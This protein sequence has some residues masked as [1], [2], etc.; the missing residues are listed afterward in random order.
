MI[1][2]TENS[3]AFCSADIGCILR[4]ADL[5]KN[6]LDWQ[7]AGEEL[8]T[9]SISQELS[10]CIQ[11][12]KPKSAFWRKT[13]TKGFQPLQSWV[14]P[15]QPDPDTAPSPGSLELL[16]SKVSSWLLWHAPAVSGNLN[17]LGAL[18]A[19]RRQPPSRRLRSSSRQG[20][21][22]LH[23]K[24]HGRTEEGGRSSLDYEGMWFPRA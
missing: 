13:P 1:L 3:W 6:P 5:P 20:A 7:R 4:G 12:M 18:Q 10:N 22:V 2:I 11:G 23:Y 19:E 15:P 9:F 16:S 17:V 8:S 24:L 14:F 21:Q